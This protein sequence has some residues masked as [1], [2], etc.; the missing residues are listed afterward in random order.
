ME[1]GAPK[2]KTLRKWSLR[3]P[4][5]KTNN[6]MEFGVPKEIHNNPKS[7]KEWS[8][9]FLLLF[10]T[11]MGIWPTPLFLFSIKGLGDGHPPSEFKKRDMATSVLISL[12]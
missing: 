6:K 11:G 8:P 1:P 3:S 9:P 5:Q 10:L 7:S 2:R 12:Q 4:Q